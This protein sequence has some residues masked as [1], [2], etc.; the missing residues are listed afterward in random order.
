MAIEAPILIAQG[1]D[2]QIVPIVAAA[3]KPIK[4]VQRGTLKVYSGAPHGIYGAYQDELD[5]DVGFI[6]N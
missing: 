6:A 2:D 1:D 3:D 4:L 5:K